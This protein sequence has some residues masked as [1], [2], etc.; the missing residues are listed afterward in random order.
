MRSGYKKVSDWYRYVPGLQ[1][2]EEGRDL[3]V[4]S[5]DGCKF[6]QDLGEIKVQPGTVRETGRGRKT[7]MEG[8]KIT[9]QPVQRGLCIRRLFLGDS[10]CL[11]L[12]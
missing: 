6:G 12:R 3:L 5:A 7:H 2:H 4:E 8:I 11:T 10:V 9:V 1:R